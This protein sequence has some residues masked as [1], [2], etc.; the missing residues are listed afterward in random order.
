MAKITAENLKQHET[1]FH[2]VLNLWVYEEIVN[3]EKL[4][5][6]INSRKEN[7]KYVTLPVTT[8]SKDICPVSNCPK[9]L[10]LLRTSRQ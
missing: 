10:M 4:S 5:A 2:P 6:V 1:L 3:G 9:I 7:V 8:N